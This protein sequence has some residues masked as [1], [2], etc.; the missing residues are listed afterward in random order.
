MQEQAIRPA[1]NA[2]RLFRPRAIGLALALSVIATGC[3]ASN[4]GSSVDTLTARQSQRLERLG[5]A[6]VVEQGDSL[7]FL[8]LS[9][10]QVGELVHDGSAVEIVLGDEQARMQRDGLTLDAECT[11]GACSR[12]FEA[13]AILAALDV[14]YTAGCEPPADAGLQDLS[15]AADEALAALGNSPNESPADAAARISSEPT[16]DAREQGVRAY[17]ADTETLEGAR[18]AEFPAPTGLQSDS[19]PVDV[20][21]GCFEYIEGC[22]DWG[23]YF[24]GLEM[25]WNR[26]R[27]TVNVCTGV[28]WCVDTWG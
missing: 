26:S 11:D 25:C 13:A 12:A 21:P 18:D 8:D 20:A 3:A 19:G 23:I 6:E 4:D 24:D 2:H 10:D 16:Q 27:C 7:V 22:T 17:E 14:E 5:I 1:A 15:C 28:Y 9:G